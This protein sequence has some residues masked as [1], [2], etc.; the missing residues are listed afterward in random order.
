[1]FVNVPLPPP[2]SPAPPHLPLLFMLGRSW[3]GPGRRQSPPL[4]LLFSS[5]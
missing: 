2:V 4:H 5:C 1:V 3:M